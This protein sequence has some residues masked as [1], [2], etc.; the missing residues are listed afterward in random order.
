[1]ASLLETLHP[2]LLALLAAVGISVARTLYRGALL[3]LGAAATALVSGGV[4]LAF[5]WGFYFYTG[6]AAGWPLPGV[7]WFVVVGLL[8]G[9]GSRYLSF[10]SMKTVGLARTSVLMQTSLIWSSGLAIAILGERLTLPI[11]AGT[12]AIMIGSVLLVGKA[13]EKLKGIPTAYYLIPVAAAM[14]QGLS[15]LFRK[16]GFVWIT[17]APL[18]MGISST[19]S[20]LCLLALMPFAKE[21]PPSAWA[22]HPLLL[23]LAGGVFNA[24][25][26]L[27]F[28][29]AVQRGELVQVIP[30]NRLSVLLMIFASWLF[31]RKHETVTSRVAIGGLLAVAGA[32]SVVWG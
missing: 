19:T 27:F 6:G 7:A 16:F 4:T 18:G 11:A 21:S 5:A 29:T 2:N 1:M 10:F 28:W 8:G 12:L 22:R 17:S 24:L 30:I 3:R 23:I 15:H 9:L 26:A 25:A 20:T 14:F 32:F 31:F 13:D